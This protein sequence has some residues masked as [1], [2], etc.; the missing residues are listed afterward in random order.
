MITNIFF[1][2]YMVVLSAPVMEFPALSDSKGMC[3]FGAN[4]ICRYLYWTK[5]K[6]TDAFF[7]PNIEEYLNID[8]F[9]LLP[10]V[11]SLTEEAKKDPSVPQCGN[12]IFPCKEPFDF[13]GIGE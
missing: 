5:E 4:A 6:Q 11:V 8:E 3:I 2:N 9:Q 7:D 13:S 10:L 1:Y 12:L